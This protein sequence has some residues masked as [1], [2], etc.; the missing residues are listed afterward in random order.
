MSLAGMWTRMYTCMLIRKCMSSY[1]SCLICCCVCGFKCVCVSVQHIHTHKHTYISQ[2]SI[3]INDYVVVSLSLKFAKW[4]YQTHTYINT[5]IHTYHSPPL[6]S[7]TTYLS[8][9]L[10]SPEMCICS[11]HTYIHTCIHT[12]ICTTALHYNQRLRSCLTLSKVR[13]SGAV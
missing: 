10:S 11:T 6:Q 4:I 8:S 12:Y 3:T 1:V 13:R 7:M 9:S 5:Y 2:P